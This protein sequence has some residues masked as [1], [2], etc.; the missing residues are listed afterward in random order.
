V[1]A[2]IS[3][4]LL[5]QKKWTEAE[6]VL[7]EVL[8]IRERTAPDDWNTFNAKSMLGGA[9]LGQEKYADA[10]PLLRAGYD[11]MKLRAGKIPTAARRPRLAEALDRLIELAE[12][13]NR[14]DDARMWNDEKAKLPATPGPKEQAATP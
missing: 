2:T 12:A 3:L 11:G 13:T 5:Q 7:R 6:T 1:L 14:P 4:N 10:E 8:A 9:L